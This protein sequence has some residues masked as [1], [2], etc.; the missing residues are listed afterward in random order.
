MPVPQ[1]VACALAVGFWSGLLLRSSAGTAVN[2]Y[3]GRSKYLHGA[4]SLLRSR[5]V[6]EGWALGRGDFG[7][8]FAFERE[9]V[10]HHQAGR[11][12]KIS[13]RCFAIVSVLSR[14]LACAGPRTS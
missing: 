14:I 13:W 3:P 12:Q 4:A 1:E 11:V 7:A 2:Q 9:L 6:A 10:N 8:A 5:K